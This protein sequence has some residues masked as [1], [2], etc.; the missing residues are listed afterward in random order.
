[1]QVNGFKPLTDALNTELFFHYIQVVD[2]RTSLRACLLLF[3]A[4]APFCHMYYLFVVHLTTL[5]VV[6]IILHPVIELLV[7]NELEMT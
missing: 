3:T 5:S 2:Q 7:N 1:M 6:H 4:E